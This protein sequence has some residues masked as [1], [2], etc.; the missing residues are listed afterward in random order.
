MTGYEVHSV[1]ARWSLR[2]TEVL[3]SWRGGKGGG[4]IEPGVVDAV[5]S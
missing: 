4:E 5:R 1:H 2:S 3:E